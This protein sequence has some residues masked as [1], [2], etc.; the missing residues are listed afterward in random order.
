MLASLEATNPDVYEKIVKMF[1][2][3]PSVKKGGK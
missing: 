3:L 1:E 2:G